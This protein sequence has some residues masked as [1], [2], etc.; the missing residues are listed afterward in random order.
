MLFQPQ[1]NQKIN[2]EGITYRFAVHPTAD[3]LPYAQEGRAATVYQLQSDEEPTRALKVF[4]PS[5]R[6]P[7]L[8]SLSDQ[9]EP[10]AEFPGLRVCRRVVLRPQQHSELLRE[11]PALIYAILMPWIEGPTW[12]QILV[13]KRPLTASQSL[14]LARSLVEILM[15]LEQ[16]RVAHCDLSG[17]NVMLPGL[18]IEQEEE[19]T[20]V[21]TE[22]LYGPGL[23]PP[24]AILLGTPGYDHRSLSAATWSV[25]ADRFSGAVL[26]AE[27]LGWSAPEVREAAWDESYF[28]PDEMQQE[29]PRYTRL[30]DDLQARWGSSLAGLFQQA[31]HSAT[32]KDCPT[33]G[34]WWIT[35]PEG[36]SA[37]VHPELSASLEER[38]GDQLQEASKESATETELETLQWAEE[39]TELAAGPKNSPSPSEQRTQESHLSRNGEELGAESEVPVPN[40]SLDNS[41]DEENAELFSAALTAYQ[42]AK[43]HEA[44][45]LLEELERR[46]PGYTEA[47]QSTAE[48][49]VEVE[50]HLRPPFMKT[51]QGRVVGVVILSL[52]VGT[53]LLG[54][55]NSDQSTLVPM[56]PS[57]PLTIVQT[58]EYDLQTATAT[59]E[60]VTTTRTSITDTI[61]RT[62]VPIASPSP[63]VV[64]ATPAPSPAVVSDPPPP[65]S[66]TSSPEVEGPFANIWRLY[67]RRLSTP[68]T[69]AY[70]VVQA[71]QPFERGYMLWRKDKDWIYVVYPQSE[72]GGV[73]TR[74]TGGWPRQWPAN[75]PALSCAASPPPNRFQPDLG[76]GWVWCELGAGSAPTGWATGGTIYSDAVTLQAQPL[77]QEFRGG[78][79]F[80]TL[81]GRIHIFFS[82]GTFQYTR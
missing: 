57:N 9:I 48:L 66:A 53:I 17:S 40:D 72:S 16:Q 5:F 38:A 29:T 15:H 75:Q 59:A 32:L 6:D 64:T 10:F 1:V 45:E 31:W 62:A 13:E 56:T 70:A 76:F 22:G 65:P 47:D 37:R 51:L 3:W 77:I 55:M 78:T 73:Y 71:E 74:F 23:S 67:E 18:A 46:A 39:A 27:M 26:L 80:R 19:V 41:V 11:H 25:D 35:L 54:T 44:R 33:F 30:I 4:K 69:R 68:L 61:T 81:S 12:M 63:D 36:I 14:S 52:V 50:K 2:I 20:L 24:P 60:H 82:D 28:A 42:T 21:D 43:W 49:L 8:V 34:E 58:L 79:V 7:S